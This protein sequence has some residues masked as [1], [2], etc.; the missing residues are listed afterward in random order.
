VGGEKERY[1]AKMHVMP[2]IAPCRSLTRLFRCTLPFTSAVLAT[3]LVLGSSIFA[4]TNRESVPPRLSGSFLQPDLGDS[5]TMDQWENEFRYMQDASVEMMVIQWTADS[6]EKTT[7][8]PATLPGYTQSTQHDV[9]E[10]VLA[11]AD[12][13]G[14][15]VYLGLQ[16]NDDWWSVYLSDPAWLQNE[17][18]LAN[19]LADEL[20]QRYQHH[21]SLAGWYLPFEVDNIDTTSAQWNNLVAFYRT[22]GKHLHRLTPGKPIV[23]SPFYNTSEGM[24]SSQWQSM[25]E[26][27]LKRSP[28]DVV[29]LQDGV[30]AGHATRAQLP[31][32][33][34]ATSNAIKNARPSTLLWADTETF[35]Q[36]YATMPI[37]S[38]VNDMVAVQSY[39]TNYL[40]F[41]F[42][43]YLSPQ[44]ANPFYYQTY[45]DY[46]AT[47]K[48]ESVPPTPPGNLAAA[49]VD[50]ASIRLS[51]S[52][53]TDNI[54]VAGYRLLRNSRVVKTLAGS[55]T[56]CVDSGL[57]AGLPYSYQIKAFDAAGNNSPLSNMASAS[58]R[59]P[60]LFPVN[61]ALGKPYV[62]SLPADVSY[63]DNANSEL[64]DGILGSTTFADA[65]WQGRAT[66][67]VY[68]FT[69]DLG[70]L[71]VIR[72]IRS[73]WLQDD[74]SGILLP[75]KIS[76]WVSNDNVTFIQVGTAT[77]PLAIAGTRLWWYTLTGLPAAS[78]R[79][80]Q[81]RVIPGS[82]AG[83]TFADEIE[84]RQ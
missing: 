65:A 62:A 44:Q 40:S 31:E 14:A 56:S 18:A 81:V 9:V 43:H 20:W 23:I 11:T 66:T 3:L 46:L 24:S 64:T 68:R 74:E 60:H 79:Y 4:A 49:A 55:E 7:I 41:S 42:N 22:V 83:W 10:R 76:Y 77:K 80:V 59:P 72:E 61:I 47:G 13:S 38:I 39:V 28:I 36:G 71:Q 67:Q 78:G 17:A 63:P 84:V 26:Y 27:V 30:G 58:T 54:G 1:T 37:H 15:K 6:K 12:Q 35:A 34:G 75:Q 57:D 70:S 51:W 32:W 48:V 45:M 25:W 2:D 50:S 8:F 16:V 33:F 53:S 73:H 21:P 5:W 52:G 82:N 69:V 19:A 29:A